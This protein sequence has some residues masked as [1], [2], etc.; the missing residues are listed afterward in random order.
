MSA[1]VT[2]G[3]PRLLIL[4]THP[5]QYQ[6]PLWRRVA[7]DQRL[8]V[9]V[10]FLSDFSVR[11]YRDA[12][13]GVDVQWTGPILE[14]FDYAF[15]GHGEHHR[16]WS[17]GPRQLRQSMAS[18]APSA[19]L[20][21]GYVPLFYWRGAAI[22]RAIGARVLCRGEAT[23]VALSRGVLK[24][25]CR[26]SVLKVFYRG[27]DM[28]LA[29]GR[30]ARRHYER[31]GVPPLRIGWSPYCVDSDHFE[32]L[33][34]RCGSERHAVRAELGIPPET[35]VI[36]FSGKLIPKKDP[37]SLILALSKVGLKSNEFFVV[38]FMGDG[39]LRNELE[40]LAAS[41]NVSARFVGFQ[42]Q[43]QVGRYFAAADMLV[44]PS[45][46][47]ETWGLVVNEALQFGLPVIVSDRVGCGPDLVVEGETGAVFP[48]RDADALAD[49]IVNVSAMIRCDGADRVR[50]RCRA[51]VSA[52]SLDAAAQG[53]VAAATSA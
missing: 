41:L 45:V 12:E 47:G 6:C 20:V 13:F 36:L 37:K 14:G 35:T 24:A 42:A 19:V 5:I 46:F 31:L 51:K 2:S 38:V 4:A 43:E 23:D 11:G 26:D 50:V 34:N 40:Q 8:K 30:N 1:G 21:N 16:A 32:V 28:C 29:I 48:A 22:A 39:E 53:I 49:Q 44:L 10:L 7:Q 3:E 9:K 18:F 33:V 17:L 52:Y 15:V 27:I 25:R